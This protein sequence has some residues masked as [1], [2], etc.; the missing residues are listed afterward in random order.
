MDIRLY[1]KALAVI[2]PFAFEKYRK[3][4]IRQ[5]IEAAR[6]NR[7]QIKSNLPKVNQEVALK[8]MEEKESSKTS[9]AKKRKSATTNLLDDNRFAAMFEN[10]DFEIDK[11]AMEYKMLTPVLSRLDK[12]KVKE[13]KRQAQKAQFDEFAAEEEVKSSDDDLFSERD[14][15]SDDDNDDRELGRDMKKQFKQIKKDIR[16]DERMQQNDEDDLKE[17]E[18]VEPKMIEVPT[19]EF[20]VKSVRKKNDK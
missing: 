2:E 20:R 9:S 14:E 19:N 7:L 10:T 4:K 5:Q 11:N 15:S 16:R 8:F 1:N 17:T 13:L 3:D 18:P 12:S 6:P